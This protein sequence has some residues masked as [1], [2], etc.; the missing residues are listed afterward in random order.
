M[1]VGSYLPQEYQ[2]YVKYKQPCSKFEFRQM[3][4]L[5]TTIN[6]TPW[7]PLEFELASYDGTVHS[8]NHEAKELFPVIY[9]INN[10]YGKL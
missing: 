6:V 8:V 5:S 3:S 2:R 7:E 4:P 9:S 1:L 10:S